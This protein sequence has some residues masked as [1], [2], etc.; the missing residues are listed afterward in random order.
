MNIIIYAHCIY[1]DDDSRKC[2]L[3][4]LMCLKPW[5]NEIPMRL[6]VYV[7]IG[8]YLTQY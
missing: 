4:N 8:K 7:E 2:R 6:A 3:N 5:S 1:I